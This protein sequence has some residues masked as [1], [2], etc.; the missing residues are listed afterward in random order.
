MA[1]VVVHVTIA[2]GWDVVGAIAAAVAACAA[3]VT[4]CLARRA[5]F[6]ARKATKQAEREWK[7]LSYRPIAELLGE[8]LHKATNLANVKGPASEIA[9]QL[10]KLLSLVV[11]HER[12]LSCASSI[13][14]EDTMEDIACKAEKA[15]AQVREATDALDKPTAEAMRRKGPLAWLC[16][17]CGGRM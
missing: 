17:V 9:V 7:R 11:G 16:K 2:T 12:D 3:L 15:L 6:E 13:S 10:D 8:I 14:K 4:V 5:L 1:A